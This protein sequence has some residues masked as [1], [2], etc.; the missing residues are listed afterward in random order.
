MFHVD[1][2]KISHMDS[3]VVTRVIEA[4][5]KRYGEIMPITISRG[6]VHDYLGMTFN[7]TNSEQVTIHIYQYIDEFL[8]NMP[9]RYKEEVGSA[10]PAPSNLYNVRDASKE[11]K[12]LLPD[13]E[14]GEYHTVTAQL[15]Y[16]SKRARP[17]LQTSIAFHYT[18][19]QHP[20][21]DDDK[22]LARTV[23]YLEKTRHDTEGR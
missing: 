21:I 8:D 16:L 22:K 2:L 13:H 7:Y 14:K 23:R 18:R 3:S 15:L 4:L 10:T 11:E 19:V 12:E 17:D 5:S 9:N 6:R 20:D 1:N